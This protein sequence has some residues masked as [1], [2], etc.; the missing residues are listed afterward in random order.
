MPSRIGLNV[1]GSQYPI[2]ID[3]IKHSTMCFVF[4]LW[5]VS[6]QGSAISPKMSTKEEPTRWRAFDIILTLPA[7]VRSHCRREV[8]VQDKLN[9]G[10][11]RHTGI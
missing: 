9:R 6:N 11:V 8:N 4:H 2:A 1:L 3:A 10:Y 5:L 7:L